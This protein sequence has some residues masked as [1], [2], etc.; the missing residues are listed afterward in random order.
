LD[1]LFVFQGFG[2]T[3]PEDNSYICTVDVA[4]KPGEVIERVPFCLI[5]HIMIHI[6]K[7]P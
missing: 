5:R 6:E 3:V 2:G 7:E 4:V 1:S